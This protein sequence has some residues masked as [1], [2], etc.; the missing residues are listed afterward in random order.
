MAAQ[1]KANPVAQAPVT[2]H[3]L[4]PAIV[5]LW[6]AALLGVGTMILPQALFD[7]I[8]VATG[9]GA[10]GFAF[11]LG[12]GMAAGLL[13][14]LIGM[15]LARKVATGR[16]AAQPRPR[17]K[18]AAADRGETRK[19]ISAM[20]EL[21]SDGLDDP[22]EERVESGRERSFG[23]PLAGRRR[24][25][26]VTDES[27]PSDYMMQVPLP[28]GEGVLDLIG[29]EDFPD[30]FNAEDA[31]ELGHF[32]HEE[33]DTVPDYSR[34]PE[35]ARPGSPLFGADPFAEPDPV[36]V[37]PVAMSPAPSA[38]EGIF[39]A[40]QAAPAMT[41]PFEQSAP[42][43]APGR[44]AGTAPLFGVPA[45]AEQT[46]A[47]AAPFAPEPQAE[48]P[49]APSAAPFSAP[50]PAAMRSVP[51]SFGAPAFSVPVPSDEAPVDAGRFAV[52]PDAYSPAP[53][54]PQMFAPAAAASASSADE[55]ATLDT[56]ALVERFA[57]ALREAGGSTS[58][59]AVA[60][61]QAAPAFAVPQPFAAAPAPAA[62]FAMPAP[63]M[64]PAHPAARMATEDETRHATVPVTEQYRLGETS[65]PAAL[66]PLSF[67]EHDEGDELE[68]PF[69]LP[70]ASMPRPFAPA[71]V[72][73]QSQPFASHPFSMPE[74]QAE[75]DSE[76]G[77]EN[78][79][80]FGSLL[81]MKSPF[82]A[83]REFVRIEDDDDD[84]EDSIE[85]VVVFPG[86]APQG[87]AMP[88]AD[89]PSRDPAQSAPFSRPPFA[90]PAAQP[91]AQPVDRNA[92]EAALRDALARLQQMSGAA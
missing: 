12:L 92:T 41:A 52:V 70:L 11:R 64:T 38:G 13:G 15:L 65:L 66:A 83:P 8:G 31:L 54:A 28:G 3:P 79:D 32:D 58:A 18:E 22:I 1:R 72:A 44:V 56:V 46:P 50:A 14:A 23:E 39:R 33:H 42:F 88:A 40:P 76:A 81:A 43:A 86:T 21:G 73:A 35:P 61:V 57:R 9:I 37:A 5:A 71:P 68:H 59:N 55:L 27:G 67:D 7:Q 89:G 17:A 87:G 75:T 69:S 30:E 77:P 2:A 26:T 63:A 24:S 34:P 85:P 6:F 36:D 49:A 78:E 62:P 90:G 47:A 20:E 19:P 29:A 84:S 45:I 60:A 10:L 80:N 51:P 82:G 25:L 48:P 4:F 74:P 16:T 91:A 53:I